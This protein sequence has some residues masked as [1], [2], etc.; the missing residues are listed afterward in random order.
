MKRVNIRAKSILLLGDIAV[1]VASGVLAVLFRYH[2]I[3]GHPR[4]LWEFVPHISLTT[5]IYL[6]C[7]YLADLY[8]LDVQRKR[9]ELLL[10]MLAAVAGAALLTLLVIAGLGWVRRS[11]LLI[12]ALLVLL[13]IY[14]WRNLARRLLRGAAVS[15]RIA[16]LGSGEAVN[17]L[18][19]SMEKAPQFELVEL[20]DDKNLTGE[21]LKSRVKNQNLDGLVV[22]D[23]VRHRPA[24][25]STMLECKLMGV[26]VLNLVDFFEA[27]TGRLP[28]FHIDDAWIVFS[29]F[30]GT[31]NSL[32]NRR[33]VRLIDICGAALGLIVGAIPMALVAIAVKLESRGPVLYSQKR[34]G[35][36]ERVFELYKFRSMVQDAE[37]DGA[38]WAREGDSRVT[39]VGAVIRSFRLD[40]M[41]Q[42]WNILKGDMSLVGPRPERPEFVELLKE[43]IPYYSLRHVV[44]PG[45]TGWAQVNYPYGASVE[46]AAEK[47]QY[48]L[49]YI[50]NRSFLLDANILLRTIRVVLF[51]IG[52]R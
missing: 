15:K 21:Q 13:L 4:S 36:N 6:F 17:A 3:A 35:L 32:Y 43:Q 42:F 49:F 47:L 45:L 33:L 26:E 11:V 1:L 7:F 23:S 22:G 37:R 20:L 38:T 8:S 9:D 50:K 46:D 34:V 2:L 14:C 12:R 41:P 52:S 27:A 51:A 18:A 44:R 48:D 31:T 25:L 28:I 5:T 10:R 19:R 30:H 40:E 39:K 29:P 24:L 16:I